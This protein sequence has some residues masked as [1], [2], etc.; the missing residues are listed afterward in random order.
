[1][2]SAIRRFVPLSKIDGCSVESDETE[3]FVADYMFSSLNRGIN[4]MHAPPVCG[5]CACL[6]VDFS[7]I[8]S[9][10]DLWLGFF[11]RVFMKKLEPA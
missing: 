1:M 4:F 2:N 3:Q 10:I 9:I 6:T 5:P 8:C 11:C 7:M